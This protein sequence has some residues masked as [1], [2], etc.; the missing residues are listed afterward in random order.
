MFHCQSLK[1]E[2]VIQYTVSEAMLTRSLAKLRI[3]SPLIRTTALLTIHSKSEG[4]HLLELPREVLQEGR[5]PL[6]VQVF[7]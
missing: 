3:F 5:K 1:G 2:L 7:L 6:S 4:V